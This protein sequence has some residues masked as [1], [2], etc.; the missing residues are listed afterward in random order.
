[1][2]KFL[3]LLFLM[4]LF[5]ACE[6]DPNLSKLDYDFVVYTNYDSDADFKTTKTYFV[7]D[8]VLTITDKDKTEY[9][10]ASEGDSI[11]KAIVANMDNR[12][13]ERIFSKEDADL[14]VQ[15]SFVKNS[16]YLLGYDN[17]YWWSGYPGYWGAGYWG[18]GYWNQWYYPYPINYGFS[19]GSLLTEIVGLKEGKVRDDQK[20][21]VLWTAYMT[22]L[23][24]GSDKVNTQLS[25][26]AINQAFAQ[27]TYITNK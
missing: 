9:L 7:A 18:S 14:G 25:V 22:G 23:I 3:A 2:R 24:S 21:P 27:S 13:Y 11:I 15:A 19:V 1:M 26:N 16:Y 17:P 10:P 6:K 4:P 5:T 12:G 20:L 8:S